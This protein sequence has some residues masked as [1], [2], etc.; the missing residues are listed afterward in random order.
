M[1][2]VCLLILF[3]SLFS[4]RMEEKPIID[5]PL[6]TVDPNLRFYSQNEMTVAFRNDIIEKLATSNQT[7]ASGALDRN[8]TAYFHVRFQMSIS[9][10]ADY[11]VDAQNSTALEM[12]VRAIEYSFRY[13]NP[14]GDFL[15]VV[16]SDLANTGTVTEGDKISGI[17]FFYSA[18][19]AG[20][21]ALQEN[22]GYQ[23][24]LAVKKRIE[25][26]VP[27]YQLSLNFLKSKTA[28]L[29]QIDA[30]APNRL[31]FDAVAFY[32]MGKYLNDPEAMNTGIDFA[33]LALSKKQPPGY[34][35][36]GNGFDSSYQGVGLAMGFRLLSILKS[37]EPIRQ[38]LYTNLA[39][40]ARWEMTRIKPT[41]E[42][43]TEGNSRVY[44]GGETFLG[45]EKQVAYTSV[46]IALWNMYYYS[47]KEEY[48]V[49][50]E[51]VLSFYL[52]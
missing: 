13:Q 37:D 21:L 19:G 6:C 1:K 36:E 40:A 15:L 20:L 34:F 16:P 11:A 52:F 24:Q 46:M 22:S 35:L 32:S 48:N 5:L 9:P 10:L 12:V 39:C 38:M 17:A 30:D 42:I 43:A 18:L 23:A 49:F 47:G 2:L 25:I 7:D 4:C 44:S 41:G 50:A 51:K 8:K 33:N 31:F 26:L 27:Q 28:L 14:D 29:K 45:K 3:C